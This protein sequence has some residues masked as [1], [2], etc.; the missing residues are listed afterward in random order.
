MWLIP[1]CS[2]ASRARSA[3]P[4]ETLD[5]A[6]AP[7]ITRLEWCPVAPN[8]AVSITR[9]SLGRGRSPRRVEDGALQ[10]PVAEGAAGVEAAD[11][12]EEVAV[13]LVPR[14]DRRRVGGEDLA[15][16]R[17]GA[18]R[19]QRALERDEQ[20]RNRPGVLPPGEVERDR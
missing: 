16:V 12:P 6:A 19:G 18:E 14:R 4:L 11:E 9:T 3:S 13:P 10:P 1:C 2:R 17:A 20:L 7:K 5:S 8:G 15:P